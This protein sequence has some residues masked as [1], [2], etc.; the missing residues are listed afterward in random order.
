MFEFLWDPLN[1]G[2]SSNWCA[3]VEHFW[4]RHREMSGGRYFNFGNVVPTVCIVD[5]DAPEV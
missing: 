3:Q 5:E 2:V 4:C 1:V